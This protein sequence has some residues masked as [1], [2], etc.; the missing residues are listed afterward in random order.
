MCP[1]GDDEVDSLYLYRCCVIWGYRW[2]I[3]ILPGLLMFST[4][5][6]SIWGVTGPNIMIRKPQIVY[7]LMVATNLVITALTA[8][9]LLWIRGTTSCV[10][11]ENMFPARCNR[12]IHIVLE[13]GAIYCIAITSVF[14]TVFLKAP[15][16]YT[17]EIGFVTQLMNIIP[18]FTLVYVG[19]NDSVHKSHLDNNSNISPPRETAS[20]FAAVLPGQSTR[21]LD[22][23]PQGTDNRSGEYV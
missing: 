2:K 17:I 14:I 18:P 23:K 7:C 6:V 1:G 3:L 8:G 9:R 19:L 11:V 16:V 15:E 22:I 10:D 21:V 20:R 4:F 5:V 13:S 12:A